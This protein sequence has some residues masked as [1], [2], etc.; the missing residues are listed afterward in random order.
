MIIQAFRRITLANFSGM[1]LVD[2]KV[3]SNN[4]RKAENAR[5]DKLTKELMRKFFDPEID[6]IGNL[7]DFMDDTIKEV[8]N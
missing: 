7:Y 1:F 4:L 8:V 2:D 6:F 3:G 5:H